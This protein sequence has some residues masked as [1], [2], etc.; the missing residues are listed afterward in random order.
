MTAT[1]VTDYLYQLKAAK[2]WAR[3]SEAEKLQCYAAQL[4][5]TFRPDIAVAPTNAPL[6]HQQMA[7]EGTVYDVTLDTGASVSMVP[8]RVVMELLE[9]LGEKFFQGKIKKSSLKVRGITNHVIS[10]CQEVTLTFDQGK[11]R[12]TIPCLMDERVEDSEHDMPILLGRNG[13]EALGFVLISPEGCPIMTPSHH[14]L[15]FN[16]VHSDGSIIYDGRPCC[17]PLGID[18][19]QRSSSAEKEESSSARGTHSSVTP[20]TRYTDGRGC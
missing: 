6:I 16:I 8:R 13:L 5:D 14:Q 1:E 17:H 20:F 2:F 19:P 18:A 11:T 15:E 7:L 9:K 12:A 10:S 4:S 3:K